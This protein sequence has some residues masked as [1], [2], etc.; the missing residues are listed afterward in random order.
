MW[1]TLQQVPPRTPA[2]QVDRAGTTIL[3][4]DKALKSAS[5]QVSNGAMSFAE[6]LARCAN[7]TGTAVRR[8][9]SE[10][11]TEIFSLQDLKRIY[12][13]REESQ[14]RRATDQG[15]KI[16]LEVVS[17]DGS[18]FKWK[19]GSD[20]A[21]YS[22]GDLLIR[23]LWRSLTGSRQ[24]RS[25][26]HPPQPPVLP[27]TGNLKDCLPDLWVQCFGLVERYGPL[28][29]LRIF[30][31]VVYVCA[32]PEV[33]DIVNQIPDKRLPKEV[34]GCKAVAGQGVFIADGQRWEFGR[35][36]LQD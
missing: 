3:H 15:M 17:T 9:F 11:G 24:A 18:N 31:D 16:D 7:S 27:T 30:D 20:H 25:A 36:A 19:W 5:A 35:H 34:F 29:K 6:L 1:A 26:R 22:F 12:E 28:V 21:H 23:P 32:D 13:N 8:L 14:V 4:L 10:D 2:Q 33:V